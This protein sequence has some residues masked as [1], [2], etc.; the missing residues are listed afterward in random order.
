MLYSNETHNHKEQK[1]PKIYAKKADRVLKKNQMNLDFD[2]FL[3]IMN[4]VKNSLGSGRT[5]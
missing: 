5:N 1:D 4:S 2:I 3:R